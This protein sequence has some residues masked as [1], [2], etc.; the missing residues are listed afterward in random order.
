MIKTLIV[1]DELKAI[2][3][4]KSLL[5][6][7]Q[8]YQICGE[9]T[10]VEEAIELTKK[11]NPDLVFLDIK[12]KNQTAFDYLSAFLPNLNF[13]IIF[14]TAF[15]EF[16]VRAFEL[17]ALDYLLKPVQHERFGQ[18]LKRMDAIV[19][20]EFYVR[21]I[22]SLEHN[23]QDDSCKIIHINTTE[24]I[25]KIHIKDI[26]FLEANNNY[27]SFYLSDNSKLTASKTL[28]HYE[29]LLEDYL[30]FRIHAKY[31]V[32]MR[33]I[34]KYR[35]RAKQVDL[36]TEITL[37]VAVRRIGKFLEAFGKMQSK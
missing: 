5:N 15:D 26:V 22:E 21:R 17:C 29:E 7:Y 13:K 36:E 31:I 16:A 28:G 32:N 1:D 10:N 33:M 30:F 37:P 8:D 19:L 11:R 6:P 27:T 9:A 24:N 25:Q 34:L 18:A 4:I 14:I 20:Q 12:L 35:K 2:G 3:T 23:L